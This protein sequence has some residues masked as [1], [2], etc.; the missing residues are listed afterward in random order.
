MTSVFSSEQRLLDV[1]LPSEL[2]GRALMLEAYF[3]ESG[4]HANSPFLC[5][6]GYLIE[7]DQ[8]KR[9]QVDWE[10]ILGRYDLPYFHMSECAHGRGAFKKL[11]FVE[12]SEICR[13]LIE[14]IKLRVEI[15][16][17]VSVCEAEYKAAMLPGYKIDAYTFCL[18]HCMQGVV[19]W[20]NKH[21]YQ[22]KISYFFEAGHKHQGTANGLINHFRTNPN[23]LAGFRYHSHSFV[24]EGKKLCGIAAADLLAWEWNAAYRNQFG[25]I[26]RS[27][28]LSFR[29]LM[30]KTHIAVHFHEDDLRGFF[31]GARAFSEGQ[32]AVV[33]EK[34][35]QFL[36]SRD[37]PKKRIGDL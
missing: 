29:S 25:P 4:T 26:R 12:R 24:E 9:F 13:A 32:P 21:N 18:Q 30:Q 28:R 17:A 11:S 23:I 1:V 14:L 10:S 3:D 15:G 20:G 22:G 34:F 7:V 27:A 6:A 35:K 37:V 5:V 31:Q 8:C 19:A 36:S 33:P 16:I 2:N